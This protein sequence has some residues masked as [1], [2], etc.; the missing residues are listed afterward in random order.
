MNEKTPNNENSKF[1]TNK[2]KFYPM[3]GLFSCNRIIL[4]A[5][6]KMPNISIYE[7]KN[8]K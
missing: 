4:F 1:G 8:A 6:Q 3:I 5:N 2:E 7:R